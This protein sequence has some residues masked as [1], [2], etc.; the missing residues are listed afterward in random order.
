M[1]RRNQAG[2]GAVLRIHK[3]RGSTKRTQGAPVS[4]GEL[5]GANQNHLPIGPSLPHGC[6]FG[7]DQKARQARAWI[8]ALCVTNQTRRADPKQQ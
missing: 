1:P 7:S 4:V 8:Q 2:Q 3:A 6:E 5:I